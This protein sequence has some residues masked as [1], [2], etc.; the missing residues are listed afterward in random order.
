MKQ[1]T[2]GELGGW[3]DLAV[4]AL[5]NKTKCSTITVCGDE[6]AMSLQQWKVKRKLGEWIKIIHSVFKTH[7]VK[8]ERVRKKVTRNAVEQINNT[9]C[10]QPEGLHVKTIVCQ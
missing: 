9:V 3:R 6:T 7:A 8:S 10:F 2:E 4:K 1:A 5:K